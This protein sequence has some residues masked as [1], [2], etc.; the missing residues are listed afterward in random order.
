MKKVNF[1]SLAAI[2]I[3]A[4]ALT[5]LIATTGINTTTAFLAL[6]LIIVTIAIAFPDNAKRCNK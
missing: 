3:A 6:E 4:I 5:C 1:I 2:V